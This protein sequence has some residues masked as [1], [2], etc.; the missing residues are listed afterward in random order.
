MLE[1]KEH[2]LSINPYSRSG[3]LLHSVGAIVMHWVGNAGSSAEANRNFFESR[4]DGKGEA[5]AALTSLWA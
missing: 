4:K 3:E 5:T 2:H 1:I